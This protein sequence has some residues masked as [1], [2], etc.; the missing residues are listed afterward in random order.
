[1]PQPQVT[2]GSENWFKIHLKYI[3]MLAALC[4]I[5]CRR[6]GLAGAMNTKTPDYLSRL[7]PG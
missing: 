5:Q 3:Y 7:P 4:E 2:L 1:M 6:L